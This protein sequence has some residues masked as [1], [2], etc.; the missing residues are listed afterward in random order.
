MG[1]PSNL[2]I[3]MKSF[4]KTLRKTYLIKS[5]S[6][7]AA[8]LFVMTLAVSGVGGQQ[9]KQRS[10]PMRVRLR[11]IK[12]LKLSDGEQSKRSPDYLGATHLVRLRFEAPDAGSVYVYAPYCGQPVG[13]TI[14]RVGGH[15]SWVGSSPAAKSP[16]FRAVKIETGSCWLLM[17]P[18]SAYEWEVETEARG[19]TEE[20]RSIFIKYGTQGKPEELISEWYIVAHA[21]GVGY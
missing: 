21:G 19:D 1:H 9:A 11:A 20:A 8:L 14:E 10:G 16:G 3:W 4:G 17:T 13:Y 7:L 15:V 18:R 5:S 2:G 12:V 6:G